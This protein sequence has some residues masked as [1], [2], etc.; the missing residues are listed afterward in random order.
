MVYFV[1]CDLSLFSTAN[2]LLLFKKNSYL[3]I[4]KKKKKRIKTVAISFVS[5]HFAHMLHKMWL[6]CQ[7]ESRREHS[8]QECV[9]PNP[10]EGQKMF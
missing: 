8:S 3:S 2:D 9:G 5:C 7:G 1:V 6:E 4:L 10:T